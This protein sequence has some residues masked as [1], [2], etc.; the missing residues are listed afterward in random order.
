MSDTLY[1]P[2]PDERQQ[3]KAPKA[4]QRK[5][6]IG[7]VTG[8][9]EIPNGNNPFQNAW[10]TLTLGYDLRFL[11]SRLVGDGGAGPIIVQD[12]DLGWCARDSDDYLFPI[13]DWGYDAIKKF[14]KLFQ[15]GEQIWNHKF[16]IK[17]PNVFDKLDYYSSAFPGYILRPN[18][19]CLFRMESGAKT[20]ATFNVV[21]IN[22]AVFSDPKYEV[23][24]YKTKKT[25]PARNGFRSHQTLLTDGDVYTPVLGH[26]LGHAINEDHILALKGDAQCKI[27]RSL[28]RCYGL[29]VEE[30]RNIMGAGTEITEIN[31]GPWV[32]HLQNM[33]GGDPMH[34]K[35]TMLTDPKVQPLPPRKIPVVPAS[36]APV[37]PSFG[38]RRL[39]PVGAGRR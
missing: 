17:P 9:L 22:P 12:K 2:T 32:D 7:G 11:D 20:S 33:V 13:I 16:L 3:A 23:P 5:T 25:K 6:V 36:K 28:D 37:G 14:V 10:L 27:N 39:Q 19:L 38:S 1:V 24:N 8:E 29:T 21:R 35:I 15:Q 30:L 4:F 34:C 31:V 26:E 18:I